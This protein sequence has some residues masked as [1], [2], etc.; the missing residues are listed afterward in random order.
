MSVWDDAEKLDSAEG[1]VWDQALALKE[2]PETETTP[3]EAYAE[4]KDTLNLSA[5]YQLPLETVENNYDEISTWDPKDEDVEEYPDTPQ[6]IAG[7]DPGFWEKFLKAGYQGAAKPDHYWEMNQVKRFAFDSYMAT[8]NILTRIGG[9]VT[10][11]LGLTEKKEVLDLYED[12]L[13]N[14][15][16]WYTKAPEAT[17]F[18]IE[19]VAEYY[20]LKGV[21]RATGLSKLLSATGRKL[22]APFVS[23]QIVAQGGVQAV[24]TLS[25]EGLKR[26]TTDGVAAFLRFAPENTAF[27]AAWSA[28]GAALQ[29]EDISEA[30]LAGGL[31]GIGLSALTPVVGGL[32]KIAIATKVGQKLQ[33]VANKAYTSLWQNHPRIMNAGRKPFSDEFLEEAK[34]QYK[35]RFGIDP[36]ATDIAKLKKMTRMVGDEI[37]RQAQKD[38]A[39]NA[40]WN[41]GAEKAREVAKE[42]AVAKK[43]PEAAVSKT[44]PVQPTKV[45]TKPAKPVAAKQ[46]A[47]GELERNHENILSAFKERVLKAEGV[48]KSTAEAMEQVGRFNSELANFAA[49]NNIPMKTALKFSI[50]VRLG[51][52]EQ[53]QLSKEDQR[54]LRTISNE[55]DQIFQTRPEER[56]KKQNERLDELEK[57]SIEIHGKPTGPSAEDI[58]DQVTG[59]KIAKQELRRKIDRARTPDIRAELQRR[60]DRLEA[61]EAPPAEVT[62]KRVAELAEKLP[63]AE[64]A[65]PITAKEPVEVQGKKFY[66]V[67]LPTEKIGVDA[68]KFQFKLGA[69]LAGGVT[70]ALKDV[71]AFDPVKAGQI[72]VWQNK[73]GK[74]FVVDGHHRVALA[75]KT[76]AETLL[77]WVL[78][79]ADG[80]TAAE[81]RA[82]GALRNLADAKGTAID[83][84]KLFRDSDMTLE[85]LRKAGVPTDNI[86]IKQGM[87]M[88]NLSDYVFRLVVDEKLPAAYAAPIGRQV[89]NDAQQ[90]QVADLILEGEVDTV[91]QAELLSATID[92]APVLTT[93]EQTLFGLETTEK[94]LFAERA[95][96][97]ANVETRLKTN[98]KVFGVLA[99]QT[100][101]IEAKGNILKKIENL[102]AKEQAEEVLFML[103][104]LANTKGPI[105][106]A[107][108]DATKEYGKNPTKETLSKVT[109]ELLKK[110]TE[111]AGRLRVPG[112]EGV[113][114]LPLERAGQKA[115]TAKTLTE[116]QEKIAVEKEL[117]EIIPNKAFV[118]KNT[119]KGQRPWRVNVFGPEGEGLYHI[120]FGTETEAKEHIRKK[121]ELGW[122]VDAQ[123][124]AQPITKPKAVEAKKLHAKIEEVFKDAPQ[125]LKDLIDVRAVKTD[126]DLDGVGGRYANGVVFVEKGEPVAETIAHETGHNIIEKFGKADKPFVSDY[127]KL[128]FA[129]RPTVVTDRFLE[130][131]KKSADDNFVRGLSGFTNGVEERLADDIAT[132]VTNPDKMSKEM[133]ALFDKQFEAQAPTEK[134]VEKPL[135]FETP[136]PELF[137]DPKKPTEFFGGSRAGFID[138][139]P[140]AK[141]HEAFMSIIEP[142]KAVEIK[143]GKDV[144]AE[145]IKA[146][147]RPDVA[148]IDFNEKELEGLDNTLGEWGKAL[149]KY[150][151]RILELLMLSRGKPSSKEGIAIRDESLE[152]LAKE[153]PELVGTRKMIN[154][155]SDFNYDYLAEVVGDDIHYVEDYFYG[156]YKDPRVVEKFLQHWKTTKR[157]TKEKKLPTVADAKAFGL[158]LRD[159][160]PVNNLRSEYLAIARLEGMIDLKAALMKSGEGVYIDKK[161]L[162]PIHW[163]EVKEPVFRDV[164]MAPELAKMINNLISTN[165]ITRQPIVNTIRQI[166]NFLRTLKFVGSAFHLGVEAKQALADSGY[167]G[168]LHKP[169]GT[170]GLTLGFKQGD[171]IFQTPEYKDYLLHG[172]GHRFSIDSEAQ[173]TFTNAIDKLGKAGVIAK[174]VALP[175]LVPE[176]FV[177]WMFEN[178]IPKV[179]YSK[180][181][182]T[183]SEQEKKLGRSLKSSEKIDIVKEA[184]N[185]YGMMNERLFGRSGTVTTALRLKFMAPGFAEGNFRTILKAILQ[186]GG[187]K[188]FSA[189]R[190]RSNIINSFIITVTAATIGTIFLTGKPPK[191]PEKLADIRD[192]FKI[193]TGKVDNH[194]RRIMIDLLTYDK[195]Y[196]DVFGS[197][198][199][200]E[201]GKAISTTVRRLG[202]MGATTWDVMSDIN[203]MS[204]GKAVYDW[205]GE[206]V[207]EITDPFIQKVLKLSIHELKK[208]EPI[209][210]NVFQQA[211]KKGVGVALSAAM[212][213]I[214]VR[215]T[216]SEQ[217]KREME[218]LHQIWSLRDQQ[219]ALFWYLGGIKNPREAIK[220]FNQTVMRIL[221][222]PI[223]PLSVKDEYEPKL[224]ID[225]QRLTA[226]KV[227]SYL[228]DQARLAEF[229]RN[230]EKHQKDI[231]ELQDDSVRDLKWLRN[232]D[233]TEKQYKGQ[234]VTYEKLHRKILKEIQPEDDQEELKNDLARFY[235]D[236]TIL[237]RKIQ[238]GIGSDRDR[239]QVRKFAVIGDNI[240]E[241]S[242]RIYGTEDGT[243]RDNLFRR[244]QTTVDR[245]D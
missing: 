42:A 2:R 130:N 21:F 1:S 222:N 180:Y 153:A 149:A 144:Y 133:K 193:D 214:G 36:T 240:A 77:T 84:A 173:R 62:P 106:E 4:G 165:K 192:L 50:K 171:P 89:K 115:V 49:E 196:W 91:R 38:A 225:E 58:I 159:P 140:L 104:K 3:E 90:K 117:P 92:S 124:E 96:V 141:T 72:L 142:S 194:G 125:K 178:Y 128:A 162:A 67:T 76:G 216:K 211:R 11:Q 63:E 182:D 64:I 161:E 40:Y 19:K 151:N 31:W 179:K 61:I 39:M 56:S 52:D 199:T 54:K 136:A 208:A 168:F 127:I 122:Y 186:W 81:A 34:R 221:D 146:I 114:Q 150:P 66:P 143:Q 102:A 154:R 232:F 100:G 57:Q 47:V 223:T 33:F 145:V 16:E 212:T 244:I 45:T 79:E 184:Q 6:L 181:L 129:D 43:P 5:G 163:D 241:I 94:S 132:Y 110:W 131:L 188:G 107:L 98:K 44:T 152:K 18:V 26:V 97:L 23:K 8:R 227:Y 148:M 156:I 51:G 93:T 210:S 207:V 103:E 24:N 204:M 243:T 174:G 20:A 74:Y 202:G 139:T 17:G 71:E 239:R 15:P 60:L 147:H 105:A 99:T 27:L 177:R 172:G 14:N 219:E 200:G 25:R 190:S 205:K 118:S 213:L 176:K 116:Q 75:K 87:D 197:I 70:A 183:V 7:P 235:A 226:N 242:R 229:Q 134:A 73:A 137:T 155:A 32:G 169:T 9:V 215:L 185:F 160:N 123:A 78:R 189:H 203:Q 109:S 53:K 48:P 167:L 191:K 198:A 135:D 217:D 157:Y 30:A 209:S 80:V 85:D 28:G 35:A 224:I 10:T 83:A 86:I 238:A 82:I 230:P 68:K 29:D 88:K 126:V 95:K 245:I 228:G 237:K 22:A 13:A 46:E 201:P 236:Q 65:E 164:R 112:Q 234:L 218:I 138:I 175:F 37:T 101:I 41:S 166:N 120:A 231:K 220:K 59:R 187:D 119:I 170:R 55:I 108:N 158:D 233:I 12:E 113:P 69:K 206:R 195:D 121:V 111:G